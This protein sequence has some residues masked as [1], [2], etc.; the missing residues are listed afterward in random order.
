[1]GSGAS[2]L[3]GFVMSVLSGS[4]CAVKTDYEGISDYGATGIVVT[5]ARTGEGGEVV[6]AQLPRR[7]RA[8]SD[9]PAI[10]HDVRVTLAGRDASVR[11]PGGPVTMRFVQKCGEASF[12]WSFDPPG[13][14][15]LGGGDA[16]L[17]IDDGESEIVLGLER[18]LEKVELSPK[19][20]TTL[21]R[22]AE[23]ELS[24]PGFESDV[25]AAT[26][27][28]SLDTPS[29]SGSSLYDLTILEPRRDGAK[30]LV[31]IPADATLGEGAKLE[32]HARV[33]LRATRCDGVRECRVGPA[34][35]VARYAVEIVD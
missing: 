14:A 19:A 31:P 30:I 7:P 33:N 10:A 1:M 8:A 20:L 9:C 21:K 17:R 34:E 4:G 22:G 13:A 28:A 6:T 27:E 11:H 23:L 16:E 3:V 26:L 2:L 12:S 15:S 24:V 18:F 35:A 32:V 5:R 25:D 29:Q